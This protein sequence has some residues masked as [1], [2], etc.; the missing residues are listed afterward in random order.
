MNTQIQILVAG[1]SSTNVALAKRAFARRGYQ[2]IP[3]NEMT[4]ALFLA[5]KNYPDLI[6]SDS[7]FRAGDGMTFLKELKLDDELSPIPFV[8]LISE[9]QSFEVDE[10]IEYGAQVIRHPVEDE[11]LVDLA[12]PL[13]TSY[14]QNKREREEQTPE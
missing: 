8:F 6:I 1:E 11:V 3:A 2:I 7:E 14:R 9:N 12:D 10:A 5:Q 13:I 4:L